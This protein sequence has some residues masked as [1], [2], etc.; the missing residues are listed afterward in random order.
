VPLLKGSRGSFPFI[1]RVFIDTAYAAEGVANP[2]RIVVEVFRKLPDQV[3]FTVL[4]RRWVL[5][6]VFAW[7]NQNT[8]LS[9]DFGKTIASA[10]AFVHA[11][12]VMLLIRGLCAGIG[13]FE[14]HS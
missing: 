14:S 11:C 12:S 3:R 7:I 9:R 6:R 2:T 4:P 13:G 10:T 5:E 1:Q 8:R